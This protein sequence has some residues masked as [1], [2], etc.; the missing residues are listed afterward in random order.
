MSRNYGIVMS[1][2]RRAL[3]LPEAE[4]GEFLSSACGGDQE[5][6]RE[7]EQLLASQPTSSG[8]T[9]FPEPEGTSRKAPWGHVRELAG[10][11]LGPFEILSLLGK[12]GMGEVYLGHDTRLERKVAVK[13]LPPELVQNAERMKRFAQEAKAVSRLNHSNIIT[14]HDIARADGIVFL[15]M[16][17][18]A[19]QSLDELIPPGGMPL[20]TALPMAVQIAEAL[21]AAHSA[22]VV[23]RDLKPGNIMV[24]ESGLVKVLDFGLAKLVETT[25]DAA[26][27]TARLTQTEVGRVVGTLGYMSPEQLQGIAVDHRSDLF[28]FGVVLY[29]MVTRE[30]AF[31][32]SS[33]M[34]GAGAILNQPPRDFG[35]SPVPP[36]LQI[37]IRKLLEK[38]PA[39]RY[40]SASE[41][42]RELK[43]LEASLAP[44]RPVNLSR[45]AW[46]AVGAAAVLIAVAAGWLWQKS[47]RERWVLETAIPEI[48]RLCDQADYGKAAALV[49]EAREVLPQDPRLDKLWMRVTGEAPFTSEPPGAEVSVRPYRG[50]PNAWET[51]GT[52]PLEKTRVPCEAYV[53]RMVKPGFVPTFVLLQLGGNDAQPGARFR[54]P[55][56]PRLRPEGTVPAEMVSVTGARSGLG[57]P[58]DSAPVVDIDGF[59]IDRHEVTNQEYKRFVDAGGYRNRDFWK[60]PFVEGGGVVP[61]EEAVARFHDATDRPGPATW[62]VGQFPNG[63]DDYPVAGVSWYEAAAY[64]EFAGKSLPTAYHWTRA[65]QAWGDAALIASGS[66]FRPEG[67]QP[68]GGE[69]TL[70]GFGTTDMAGNVKEWCWN[71]TRGAR[72]LI[73]GGGFGEPNYMFRQT[74]AQ[75][76]WERRSNYGFR[77][78]KTDSPLSA[79]AM[80]L[81]EPASPLRDYSPRKSPFRMT[82][83]GCLPLCTPTTR[84]T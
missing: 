64:A 39:Q 82:P 37:I 38:D 67:T 55:W 68:V 41:V 20:K 33:P 15:V 7:V 83:S 48:E 35:D 11:R 28:S 45:N 9:D 5:L 14:L 21:A 47:S 27:A 62:E 25:V 12:G 30:R 70:S 78:A 1:L 18:V 53:W 6:S 2:Y 17:Y 16:E 66:N 13:V 49:R 71:E 52:T 59:L 65:S 58:L 69:G 29:E 76:P 36:R 61:W 26:G 56:N 40:Q 42:L 46:I 50:D 63:Q 4:R 72:R 22:G 73:L 60:Q 80:A 10:R 44:R 24:T 32:G 77:C 81:V 19:G 75:S 54:F 31:T 8:L 74:D 57:Y 23:H 34:A 84:G 79:E 3:S 43:A 51:I